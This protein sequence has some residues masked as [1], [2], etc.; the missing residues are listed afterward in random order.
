[1]GEIGGFSLSSPIPSR[2]ILV[3]RDEVRPLSF[4]FTPETERQRI[5]QLVGTLGRGRLWSSNSWVQGHQREPNRSMASLPQAFVY[6][7]LLADEFTRLEFPRR[8]KGDDL[9]QKVLFRDHYMSGW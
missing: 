2:A 9:G 1:M 5:Q 7:E 3:R 6:P 8:L 4:E